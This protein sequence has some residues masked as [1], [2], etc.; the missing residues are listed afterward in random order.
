MKY[1]VIDNSSPIHYKRYKLG[2]IIDLPMSVGMC[3]PKEL[4]QVE[5]A[6]S[7]PSLRA[8]SEANHTVSSVDSGDISDS[9]EA[10]KPASAESEES[11]EIKTVQ[12]EPKS[13]KPKGGK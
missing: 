6:K 9:E 4:R 12:E 3:Y 1:E 2:A 10:Q 13:A 5:E 11:S 8:K 7:E